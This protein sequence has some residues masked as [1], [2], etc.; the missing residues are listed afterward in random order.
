MSPEGLTAWV[1]VSLRLVERLDSA[2]EQSQADL[3]FVADGYMRAI[4]SRAELESGL[5]ELDARG[6]LEVDGSAVRLTDE[7]RAIAEDVLNHRKFQSGPAVVAA[8]PCVHE[9]AVPPVDPL[10]WARARRRYLRHLRAALNRLRAE[11]R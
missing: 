9:L 2:D 1:L 4:P 11:G 8:T 6:W 5:R 7:A 10:R 3:S